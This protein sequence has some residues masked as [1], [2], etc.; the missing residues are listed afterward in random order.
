M[1]LQASA[2]PIGCSD[3]CATL[4]HE[5]TRELKGGLLNK[6][7]YQIVLVSATFFALE[8]SHAQAA[9]DQ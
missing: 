8:Q 2:Y 9:I 3:C 5:A 6:W 1:L 4:R 7:F